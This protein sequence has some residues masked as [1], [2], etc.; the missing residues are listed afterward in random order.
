[1]HYFMSRKFSFALIVLGS[2][3]L[4]SSCGEDDDPIGEEDDPIGEEIRRNQN[5][6]DW[7][8]EN[9]DEWYLWNDKLPVKTNKNLDPKNYFESL[10]YRASDRFSGIQENFTELLESLSGVQ[11]EAGYDFTGGGWDENSMA[12]L[13]TYVKPNSPASQAGLKRGDF[14]LTING[15]RLPRNNDEV[16]RNLQNALYANHTLEII[17]G[18]S[19]REVPL[20][21]VKYEENPIF[22][23]TVYEISNKKI[24][25]LIYNFFAQDNGDNSLAYVK[26]LNQVFG[27]LQEQS[28]N[29]LILDLRY[30]SG[31]AMSTSVALAS[32]IANRPSSDLFAKEEY[33]SLLDSYLREVGG[34]NYNKTF[35]QDQIEKYDMKGTVLERVAINKLT[36]LNR[37]YVLTSSNRTASAS[38]LIINGLKP[39]MD[40]VLIG[41]TTVGKNVGSVILYERDPQKQK[42]NTW[43]M[44]PIVFKIMNAA[45]SSDYGNGFLPDVEVD[46]YQEL[47]LFPLFPLGDTEEVMLRTALTHI[48][49]RAEKNNLRAEKTAPFSFRPVISSID[50]TPARK[51]VVLD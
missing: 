14:F 36:G 38:E 34:A 1:M 20:S 7:I 39:Y 46:E 28:I 29:E 50:L 31:G 32:M 6:N 24:G 11:L 35:F 51:N 37:I 33:N 25:Y 40:V 4:F 27:K 30:N 48:G 49:V 5:V 15:A 8:L 12:G 23:D 21:V 10:L 26:E 22:L 9:M 16:L 17:E 2:L 42:N 13:I 19:I 3:T 41:T 47:P 18:N 43:G 44:L 45:N